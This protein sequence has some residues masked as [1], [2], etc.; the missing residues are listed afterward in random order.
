MVISIA[1]LVYQRL[2]F[3]F[4]QQIYLKFITHHTPIVGLF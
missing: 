2:K 1:I 4:A 3:G